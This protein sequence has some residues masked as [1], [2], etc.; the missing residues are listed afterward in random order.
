[1]MIITRKVAA[2]LLS[3]TDVASDGTADQN[4]DTKRNRPRGSRGLARYRPIPR[5]VKMIA[6]EVTDRPGMGVNANVQ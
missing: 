6:A 3:A 2:N 5:I 4:R 1:M